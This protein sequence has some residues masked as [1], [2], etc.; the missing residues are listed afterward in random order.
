MS[1]E[2]IHGRKNNPL[3]SSAIGNTFSGMKKEQPSRQFD[4]PL[5]VRVTPEQH[6]MF[7]DAAGASGLKLSAWARTRLMQAARR[8]LKQ[9][10]QS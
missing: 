4:K 6:K 7:L 8:D 10:E 9:T 2:K 1:R 3:T 5:Q